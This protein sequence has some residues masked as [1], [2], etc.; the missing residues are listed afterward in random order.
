MKIFRIIKKIF[1]SKKE[2]NY[3]DKEIKDYY[4]SLVR[5]AR[6]D[7]ESANILNSKKEKNYAPIIYHIQQGIE[8]LTKAELVL[9]KSIS[10]DELKRINHKSPKAFMLAL[11]KAIQNKEIGS[12][13]KKRIPVQKLKEAEKLIKKPNKIINSSEEELK[14]IL[15]HYSEFKKLSIP[16][17]LYTEAKEELSEELLKDFSQERADNYMELYFLSWCTFSHAELTRY[18][19]KKINP[20]EYNQNKGIVKVIPLLIKKSKERLNYMSKSQN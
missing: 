12:F 13:I 17:K 1:N 10:I 4:E 18:P 8:K 2:K 16:E 14:L 20:W 9:R 11:N 5:C 15:N 3:S 6:L 19:N 7:I